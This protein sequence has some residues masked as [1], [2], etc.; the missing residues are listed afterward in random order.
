MHTTVVCDTVQ[1]LPATVSDRLSVTAMLA[2]SMRGTHIHGVYKTQDVHHL[3]RVAY[4]AVAALLVAKSSSA[5]R[6]RMLVSM[7]SKKKLLAIYCTLHLPIS[8][9]ACLVLTGQGVWLRPQRADTPP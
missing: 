8:Y 6:L 3:F 9:N 4:P 2:G 1:L 7:P 5:P